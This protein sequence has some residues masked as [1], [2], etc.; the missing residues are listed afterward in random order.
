MKIRLPVAPD[1]VIRSSQQQGSTGYG[2]C[3][4]RS[5]DLAPSLVTSSPGSAS[6]TTSAF[7]KS[8]NGPGLQEPKHKATPLFGNAPKTSKG[9]PWSPFFVFLLTIFQEG[10]FHAD[11]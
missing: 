2:S 7:C 4:F 5:C 1:R 3:S 6:Q 10:H 11:L 9:E 8:R